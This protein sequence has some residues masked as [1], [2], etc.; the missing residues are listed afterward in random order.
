MELRLK[1]KKKRAAINQKVIK[2]PIINSKKFKYLFI[3]LIYL[4][5]NAVRIHHNFY[6]LF[7]YIEHH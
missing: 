2:L 6:N 3:Y 4:S 5:E 7:N 1:K